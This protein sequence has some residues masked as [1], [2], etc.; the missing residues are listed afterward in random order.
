MSYF[1]IRRAYW[2]YID[3]IMSSETESELE[4][5]K[6]DNTMKRL[7]TFIKHKRSDGRHI[8]PLKSKGLLNSEPLE[9]ANIINNQF[10]NAFSKKTNI[11]KEE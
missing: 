5:G 1:I 8:P 9:K 3:G 6:R 2:K 4:R 10:Q 7:W 11:S